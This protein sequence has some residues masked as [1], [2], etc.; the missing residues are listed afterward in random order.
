MTLGATGE[1]LGL[2]LAYQYIDQAD[3]EGRTGDG[4]LEEPTTAVNNGVY[5]FSAHLFG[6]TLSYTF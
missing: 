6:L 1:N 4:G 2:D 5:Q 3:R